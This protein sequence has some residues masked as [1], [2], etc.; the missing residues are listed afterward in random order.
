MGFPAATARPSMFGYQ[1]TDDLTPA[2]QPGEW[3][4]TRGR[5]ITGVWGFVTAAPAGSDFTAD[6]LVEGTPVATITI[7][8]GDQEVIASISPVAVAVGER[9]SFE[10]TDDAGAT[11]PADLGITYT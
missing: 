6:V 3:P 2:V 7:P 4:D 1:T 8:D 10:I 9:I 11:G 5:T